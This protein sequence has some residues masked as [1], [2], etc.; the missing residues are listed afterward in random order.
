MRPLLLLA[1]L[2]MSAIPFACYG[3]MSFD[4]SGTTLVDGKPFFPVGIYLYSFDSRILAEVHQQGFN[5]VIWGITP[6]DLD[7]LKAH[8][9]MT[10]ANATDEWLAAKDHP[11]ILAWYLLDEPEGHGKTPEDMRKE[12][13]RIQALDP[14]H[15]I[16]LCHY[17]WDALSKYKDS[18]DFVMSDVYPVIAERGQPL[19]PMSDHLDQIHRIHGS[20]FPAWPVIQIFGGPNTDGGKWAEP[21]PVEVR[22]M[23]YLSLAHGAK[24]MLYFSYWPQLP[25]TWAEVSVLA[26]ELHRLTPFL[27]A[28]SKALEVT[29]SAN[30]I[31]TRCLQVGR[32]GLLIA[33]NSSPLFQTAALTIP[34][35]PSSAL[36]LPFENHRVSVKRGQLTD[37]FMPYGVHVYQ[38]GEEPSL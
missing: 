3:R 20:N 2:L 6:K 35:L 19:T 36:S 17:L 26:R 15:P 14:N 37:R 12:Y 1:I 30:V 29:S 21:T 28:P 23:T 27:V 7:T 13:E 32:S 38:W 24:A 16:G 34:K 22:C 10:V 25:R 18:A 31:H 4:R 5:T 8:G 11:S 33:V 9:L